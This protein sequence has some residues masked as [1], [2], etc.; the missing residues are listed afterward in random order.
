MIYNNQKRI[1]AIGMLVAAISLSI[2]VAAVSAEGFSVQPGTRA[3]WIINS[4]STEPIPWYRID[5]WTGMGSWKTESGSTLA[6][7]VTEINQTVY[8]ELVLGNLTVTDSS[9]E[10]TASNLIL[11]IL[12]WGPG[13]ITHTDWTK[14]IEDANE[15]TQSEWI[16]GTLELTETPQTFLGK[17]LETIKFALVSAS[18]NTTLVYDKGSGILLEAQTGFGQ[19]FLEIEISLVDPP[20]SGVPE[21]S[22]FPWMV[23]NL[24]FISWIGFR[25]WKR[26][27]EICH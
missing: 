21:F 24:Q 4:V 14:H 8:G 16:N 17:M 5:V 25:I 12:M 23:L 22:S 19:Y 3:E 20:L 6:Y 27:K 11:G 7:T 2:G 15:Q 26:R 13:L 10:E 18:Q 1:Q 9:S